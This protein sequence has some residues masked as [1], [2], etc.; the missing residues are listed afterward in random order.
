VTARFRFIL[1]DGTVVD[2][3]VQGA[4]GFVSD[5]RVLDAMQERAR[6]GEP[7]GRVYEPATGHVACFPEHTARGNGPRVL[8]KLVDVVRIE[9][10]G[11]SGGGQSA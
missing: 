10:C 9:P 11:F 5:A 1:G 8:V 3:P 6:R 7:L 4:G 2:G